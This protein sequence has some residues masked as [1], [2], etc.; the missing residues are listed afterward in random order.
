MLFATKKYR[1][2]F[3][4]LIIILIC[5]IE[6]KSAHAWFFIWIPGSLTGRISDAITGSEGEH[7]VGTST[8]VGD[9]IRLSDGVYYTVK[10]LSGSS[11]RCNVSSH[12]I[13]ALLSPN[14][15]SAITEE[16]I[17]TRATIELPDGW[18][19][20][21]LSDQLRASSTVLFVVNKTI[22][23]GLIMTSLN[24]VSVTD[25]E[26]YLASIRNGES[27]RFDNIEISELIKINING[28]NAWQYELTAN[29]RTALR[30]KIRYLKTFYEGDEEIIHVASWTTA[31]NYNSQ[32]ETLLKIAN[33]VTG[34]KRIS[35]NPQKEG[36]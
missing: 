33:S 24:R 29:L 31:S 34:L 28:V 27:D 1:F 16:K 19:Q 32:R 10:S 13:R 3:H 20:Q 2:F 14:S 11:V 36:R 26:V 25:M 21:P 17:E 15:R 18:I 30:P 7:C 6:I 5:L 8:K 4:P 22:D 23:A 35:Q 9:V 12:P